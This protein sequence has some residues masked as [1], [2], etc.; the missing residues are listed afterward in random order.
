MANKM[1]NKIRILFILNDLRPSNG[2][3]SFAMTYFRSL[4]KN[5][6]RIDFSILYD[7]PSPYYKEIKDSGSKLFLLP[8]LSTPL[9]H[10]KACRRIL[11]ENN[12]QIVHDN[13]LISSF[14]MML[15]ALFCHVPVRILQSHN[16][17]LSAIKW[18]E[19]RNRLF[20][21]ALKM[22]ANTNFACGDTAGRAMFG[23]KTF[24]VIPNAILS[25]KFNFDGNMRNYVRKKYHCEDK[26]VIG[27]V[28]R[29]AWQ[30]NPFFAIKVIQELIKKNPNIQYWWIGG[31]ELDKQ[32]KEYIKENHLGNYIKLFGSRDDVSSLYQAMD[33]Y[34]LPSFFEGLPIAAIEAQATGLPCVLSDSITKELVYT[35]LVQFISLDAPLSVWRDQIIKQS[36]MDTNRGEYSKMLKESQ[37]YAPNAAKG[38]SNKY[39]EL[40]KKYC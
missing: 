30:K 19:I 37:F 22:T 11:L 1:S 25:N 16:T 40:I 5:K 23:K 29:I 26:L 28:A 39:L 9:R 34:L 32:V 6:Y 21:P 10:I 3:A 17:R 35:D 33:V 13:L 20:L 7:Y 24:T 38:L 18:K 8:K 4:D 31:G 2:V 14:P 36:E 12:Y 27:T 15:M